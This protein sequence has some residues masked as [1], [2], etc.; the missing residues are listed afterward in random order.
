MIKNEIHIEAGVLLWMSGCPCLTVE[1][2]K[3]YLME[4]SLKIMRKK[5]KMF[6]LEWTI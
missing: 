2:N 1:G 6:A 5:L 3:I 4:S